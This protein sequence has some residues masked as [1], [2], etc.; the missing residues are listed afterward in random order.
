MKNF[1]FE[2]FEKKYENCVVKRV[3]GKSPELIFF[4]KNGQ[5]LERLDI[6]KMKR[7]ELNELV[8]A[9]GIALKQSKT[10][11]DEP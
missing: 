4:N 5:E 11:H 7:D 6:S 1:I 2:D 9:K 3:P 8:V 10:V